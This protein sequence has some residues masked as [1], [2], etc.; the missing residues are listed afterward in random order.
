MKYDRVKI[1]AN[2]YLFVEGSEPDYF[3]IV[4]KG[5]VV[6]ESKSRLIHIKCGPGM[7]F[8]EVSILSNEKRFSSAYT[9]TDTTLIRIHKNKIRSVFME[10]RNLRLSI[11]KNI[12]RYLQDVD[13][14]FAVLYSPSEQENESFFMEMIKYNVER[15]DL[16]TARRIYNKVKD[17][18]PLFNNFDETAMILKV[19][20]PDSVSLAAAPDSLYKFAYK[21]MVIENDPRKGMNCFDLFCNL[22]PK[23]ENTPNALLNAAKCAL[24]INDFQKEL[25]YLKRLIDDY[26][27]HKTFP[28]AVYLLHSLI[29]EEKETLKALRESVRNKFPSS[30]F[31]KKIE[32]LDE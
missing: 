23:D 3:Y 29:P 26:P 13:E 9:T 10:N 4:E 32:K 12:A 6:L 15:G 31:L 22:Y 21:A 11:L 14:K 25:S 30:P 1:A 8:G 28:E 16:K 19:L 24:T 7:L 20:K 18:L 27:D 17:A 5:E 2:S